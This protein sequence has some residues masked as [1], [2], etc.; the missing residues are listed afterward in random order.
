[1]YYRTLTINKKL[2]KIVFL[3]ENKS[4]KVFFN[5]LEFTKTP[6]QFTNISIYDQ[7]NY[8]TENHDFIKILKKLN[9]HF[10]LIY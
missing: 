7:I 9:I 8:K 1:M 5:L 2:M 3:K 6:L 4:Y 10:L